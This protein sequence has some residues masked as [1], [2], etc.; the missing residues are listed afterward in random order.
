MCVTVCGKFQPQL[1]GPKTTPVIGCF[2]QVHPKLGLFY[3]QLAGPEKNT[4]FWVSFSSSPKSGVEIYHPPNKKK[5]GL[6]FTYTHTH[7]HTSNFRNSESEVIFYTTQKKL[8]LKF[9]PTPTQRP[10]FQKWGYLLPPTPQLGLGEGVNFNPN[11]PVGGGGGK[12]KALVADYLFT[13][14]L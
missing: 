10:K 1:A 4:C 5:F 12:N 13:L 11:T 8:G 3:P 14:I 2:F 9:T 7:T 6:K